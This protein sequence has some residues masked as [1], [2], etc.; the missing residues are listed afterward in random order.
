[1]NYKQKPFDNIHIRQ[2][3]ALAINKKKIVDKI[4]KGS[5]I[6]TNHIIAQGMPSTTVV[7]TLGKL[8]ELRA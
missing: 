1:M 7:I 3:L 2:A 4:W 6:P 8:F 5:F